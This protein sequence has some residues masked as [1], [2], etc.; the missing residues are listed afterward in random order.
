MAKR[1]V[2]G[3]IF[4]CTFSLKATESFSEGE[5]DLEIDN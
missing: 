2:E 3:Q 4:Q 1:K 5:R